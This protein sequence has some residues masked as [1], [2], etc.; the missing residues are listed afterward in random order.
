MLASAT[1]VVLFAGVAILGMG[2]SATNS[3]KAI[4][5]C[6]AHTPTTEEAGFISLLQA[7][8]DSHITGS[9]ALAQSAPLNA[10]AMG[11]AQFLADTPG[12][13]GHFAD[14]TSG[15]PWATRAIQCGYPANLAAG[16]EG[17]AVVE[18]SVSVSVSAQQALNTM[19][20]ENG[21]GV[22][23]PSNV[24][25]PVKCV[26]VGKAVS[27]NGKKVAW[28]TLI[29]AA[30]T[31]CP[32]QVTGGGNPSPSA[33]PSASNSPTATKTA[34]PTPSR[35]PSPTPTPRA[36]GAA[37]TI[38]E[39]WN[40]VVLPSGPV[41]DVLHRA[42]GCYRSVYQQQDGRWLHYSPAVPGY[43]NNLQTLNGGTFWVEGTAENCGFVRL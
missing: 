25:L 18:S 31:T 28:V 14:G 16:G 33:S 24:G 36:D 35:T 38:H 30:T 40:L 41:A 15:F 23:V 34:S 39:G 42:T 21:G 37:V 20:A 22:W 29:F 9:F 5:P 11:F 43:A 19:T 1:G 10:A 13:Q 27:A 6:V 26:G 4:A 12:A 2:S 32:Q 8:R 17:L 7:W 3:A